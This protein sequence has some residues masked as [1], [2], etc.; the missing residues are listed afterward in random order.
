MP[1]ELEER[2][3]VGASVLGTGKG[4]NGR[5]PELEVDS[6]LMPGSEGG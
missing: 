1:D 5:L 3:T 6:D 4:N 2:E